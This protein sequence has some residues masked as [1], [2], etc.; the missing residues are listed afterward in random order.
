M[1]VLPEPGIHGVG[2]VSEFP[3]PRV[4]VLPKPAQHLLPAGRQGR[5]GLAD[6]PQMIWPARCPL[7]SWARRGFRCLRELS[8]P[9]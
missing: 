8:Q 3:R 1:V 4:A 2:F 9:S 7:R 5:R 6:V